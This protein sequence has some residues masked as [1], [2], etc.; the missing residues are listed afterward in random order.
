VIELILG[1]YGV[2]CWLIFKKFKLV[3]IT[4]YTVCTAVL[5]GIVILFS[6][7]MIL[8]V[9][10]PVSHD[11]RF[12]AAVTQ[13]VPQVRGTVVAVPVTSNTPLRAGDVLF[14]ID[15]RPYQL[16]VERLEAMLA[17]MNTKVAQLDARLASAQAATA[18]ARSNLLVSESEYDRQA[19]I[20]LASAHE[21][22]IGTQSRLTAA[23]SNLARTQQLLQS[24]A[25]TKQEL[26]REIAQVDSL[27]AALAQAQNG[28][29]AAQETIQSGGNRLSAVRDEV[30]RA[31]AAENEARIALEAES[32]GVNPDVRQT[33][34]ELD[35]KRW[36]LEQTT[37]TAPSDGYV[38]HLFLRPGQMAT[39]FSANAAMM[40]VTKEKPT[41]IAS[42]PQNAIAGIEPGLEAELAF[43]AYPG[44][45]FKAKVG[46]VQ[47]ILPEGTAIGSGQLRT[48]TAPSASGEVPVIFEYGEDVDALNLPTGAQASVAVYT[49]H[50]HALSIVRKIILRIKSWENYAF[51]MQNFD[52]LH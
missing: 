28:E 29:R 23:N 4:T 5:G 32:D 12:Y 41:L 50:F 37:I 6:L 19:R 52:S 2:G 18:V 49:H 30:K 9:C 17:G 38:T 39:P 26:E 34:A 25:V 45:I 31:E 8:S 7:L 11:G 36:E 3:P 44:R 15:P 27:K 13:V 33:M 48:T 46:R 10:H 42:F 51:F 21:Q 1:T 47:P 20:T 16:E 40:F 24:K 43:K 22:I 35:R 14:R